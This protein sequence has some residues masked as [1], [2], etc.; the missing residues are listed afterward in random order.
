[1]KCGLV[2][3]AAPNVKGR[4]VYDLKLMYNTIKSVFIAPVLA[5]E[6]TNTLVLGAWGCGV[7]GCDPTDVS[8]LFAQAIKQ[9][10]LGRLYTH[11]HF[12]IPSFSREDANSRIFA[13]TLRKHRL[14]FQ[15]LR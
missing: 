1:M 9:D 5:N 13:E 4:E 8:E 7:F 15:E 2:T 3:A 6:R 12:A 14:D 10:R 11:I